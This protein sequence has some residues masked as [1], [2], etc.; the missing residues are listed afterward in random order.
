MSRP[1]H[2][3]R[4]GVCRLSAHR[5][6]RRAS[7]IGDTGGTGGRR[8]YPLRQGGGMQVLRPGVLAGRAQAAARASTPPDGC[9]ARW[10]GLTAARR[11]P[12]RRNGTMTRAHAQT[13]R[14]S[15]RRRRLIGDGAHPGLPA[16]PEARVGTACLDR[17][18]L[19]SASVGAGNPLRTGAALW[20]ADLQRRGAAWP[21]E[22]SPTGTLT[23]AAQDPACATPGVAHRAGSFVVAVDGLPAI[24]V[25]R[26]PCAGSRVRGAGWRCP[27]GTAPRC[28]RARRRLSRGEGVQVSGPSPLSAWP[29]A[30]TWARR[31]RSSASSPKARQRAR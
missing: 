23:G 12:C 6:R 27:S 4:V 11:S 18:D 29:S 17:L 8:P 14:R 13:A 26:P 21:P 9:T 10:R 22:A 5:R 30:P 16:L 1:A 3:P 15:A 7:Q 24:E 19:A 31:R 25:Q 2:T 28:W 20:F